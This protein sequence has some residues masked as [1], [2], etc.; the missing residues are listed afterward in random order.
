MSSAAQVAY[1]VAVFISAFLNLGSAFVYAYW[2]WRGRTQSA[3]ATWIL[4]LMMASFGTWMYWTSPSHSLT[5]NVSFLAGGVNVVIIFMTVI[6]TRVRDGTI[7]QVVF[8]PV[9]RI[10]LV[11]GAIITGAWLVTDR[12]HTLVSYVLVQL[13][14]VMAYIATMRRLWRFTNTTEPYSLW[15]AAFVGCLSALYPAIEKHDVY[16]WIYLGRA[17][18]STL[19]MIVLLWRIKRRMRVAP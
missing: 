12:E 3:T 17:T 11:G 1:A 10:C 18:P 6:A 9:Q 8:E 15:V 14:G 4:L 2:T 19:G 13:L 7:R 5:G 16:A